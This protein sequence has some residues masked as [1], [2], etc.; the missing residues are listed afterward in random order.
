MINK[1]CVLIRIV[2]A[3]FFA[4][5]MICVA[6]VT[7]GMDALGAVSLPVFLPPATFDAGGYWPTSVAIADLNH[8]GKADVVVSN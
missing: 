3:V 8:D 7:A 1:L 2:V 5:G 6:Q 4:V